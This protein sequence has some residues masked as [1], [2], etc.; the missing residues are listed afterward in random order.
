MLALTSADAAPSYDEPALV[1]LADGEVQLC[2]GN[3]KYGK[4]VVYF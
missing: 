1:V 4:Y 3:G 2:P